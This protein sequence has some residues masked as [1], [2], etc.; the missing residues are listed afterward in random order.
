VDPAG[1]GLLGGGDMIGRVVEENDPPVI[2]GELWSWVDATPGEPEGSSGNG[3]ISDS[4]MAVASARPSS[5]GRTAYVD[6]K[7]V[8]CLL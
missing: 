3:L 7:W 8:P 4:G 5:A 2:P 6:Q 1:E